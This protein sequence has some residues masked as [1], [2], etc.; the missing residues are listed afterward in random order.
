MGGKGTL[1]RLGFVIAVVAVLGSLTQ[2]AA[3]HP[4][5][6]GEVIRT[7]IELEA[8]LFCGEDGLVVGAAGITI[9][10]GGHQIA[11]DGDGV[12]IRNEGF[13]SVVITDGRI[14]GFDRGVQIADVA[15]NLVEELELGSNPTVDIFVDGGRAVT[16]DDNE[17]SPD[18]TGILALDTDDSVIGDNEIVGGD[19]AI[20]VKGHRNLIL[21]NDIADGGVGLL[22]DGDD[23]TVEENQLED[24]SDNGIVVLGD[25]NLITDNEVER[26]RSG[27][28]I[29]GVDGVG[30]GNRLDGNDV[31]GS[32]G[33][34]IHVDGVDAEIV[35]NDV[36]DNGDDGIEV[37][38][39]SPVI[40]DNDADDNADWGIDADV[41][42]VTGGDNDADDNGSPCRPAFL[43]D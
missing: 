9:D 18:A 40:A 38:G 15:A 33:D 30:S 14:S 4:V 36:A 43:C 23:N 12:G 10:L 29:Q 19:I 7:S 26:H 25:D 16:I 20:A 1:S 35:D 2:P 8:D 27:I 37:D 24:G 41:S 11:G 17:L 22:V 28:W 31:E 39:E 42:G 6:C 3:A 5:R 13:D 32:Q 21:D 34:G